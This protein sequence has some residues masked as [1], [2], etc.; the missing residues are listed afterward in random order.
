MIRPVT[1]IAASM[2]VLSGAYLFAV[3][4]RAQ[5]LDNELASVTQATR[6]DEQ[7]IRVLQAQWALEADPSRLAQLSTEFTKLQPMKPNQLV[8][9]ASL[10]SALPAPGSA[11]PGQNPV[12]AVPA[13]PVAP[14]AG[15]AQ[16]AE[17]TH[18]QV[19]EAAHARVAEAAASRPS[20]SAAPSM[21]TASATAP[22]RMASVEAILHNL[23]AARRSS[24]VRH[25]TVTHEYAENRAQAPSMLASQ[26]SSAPLPPPRLIGAQ[27]M[28]VRAVTSAPPV[29]PMPSDGGSML[30]MAQNLPQNRSS[31]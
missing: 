1:L 17:A 16:V 30:G 31:N 18:A 22:A 29:P 28:S 13:M 12:D 7:R 10:G 23:P 14:G 6:L 27:V 19:A 11:V 2:F 15:D 4:H 26:V 25:N 8:T 5:T 20:P 3:K 24:H 9:L 21:R